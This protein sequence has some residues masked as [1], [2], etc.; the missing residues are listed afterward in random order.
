MGDPQLKPEASTQ[1]DIWLD[2]RYP[3]VQVHFGAFARRVS[4]YITIEPTALP[5]RLP[6]S[7]PTVYQYINGDATFYGLEGSTS[8]GL[9]PLFTASMNGSYLYGQDT[10]LDDP[11]IGVTPLSGSLSLRYEEPQGRFYLEALGNAVAKQSRVSTKRNEGVTPGHKTADVRG[12]FGFA[13]GVTLRGGVL[14]VFDA[15]YWDHLNARNPFT[16]MPVPEPGR[17]FFVNLAWAF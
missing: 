5:T 6:L 12:G 4:D 11:A 9:G 16:G 7:P 17:V 8:V 10:K 2:G 3:N 14:N 15:Y 1:G 13:N